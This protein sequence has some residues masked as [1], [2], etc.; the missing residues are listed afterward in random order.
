MT[1][2]PNL[3]R[4]RKQWPSSVVSA[5]TLMRLALEAR[6]NAYAPYSGFKVGAACLSERDEIDVGC[7]VENASYGLTQCA[8]R[9]ALASSR[10]SG[11]AQTVAIA[12]AG[13]GSRSC[14]PC[15]ACRQVIYERNPR[16]LVVVVGKITPEVFAIDELLPFAFDMRKEDDN[17]TL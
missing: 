11:H 4:N 9:S 7:N 13:K 1:Y 16:M 17:G 15:G 5:E 14:F 8:E 2:V 3:N 12:V 10:V 6:E